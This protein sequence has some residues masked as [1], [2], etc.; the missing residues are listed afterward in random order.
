MSSSLLP[1][2]GRR[3][4]LAFALGA[5]LLSGCAGGKAE[6]RPDVVWPL[7]PEK[8]RVKF[9]RAF[10]REDDLNAGGF[11]TALRV[12]IPASPDAVIQQP[13]GLALSPD[14]RFL[15]VT[16]ASVGRVIRV[17]LRESKL[18]VVSIDEGKQPASPFDVAVDGQGNLYISDMVNHAVWAYTP[19]GKF[20]LKIPVGDKPTGVAVDPRRQLLYVVVGVTQK[21]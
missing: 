15:Y 8:A 21:T 13:T 9:L 10:A 4:V 1:A 11:Q 7:P 18:E 14:G 6:Q 17:D 19:A 2:P 12:V 5:G 3:L 20:L 16:C